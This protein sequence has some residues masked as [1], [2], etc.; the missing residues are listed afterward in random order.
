MAIGFHHGDLGVAEI[1]APASDFLDA[2]LGAAGPARLWRDLRVDPIAGPA[3][4][5]VISGVYDP[6]RDADEHLAIRDLPAAFDL[7]IH[8]REVTAVRWLP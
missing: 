5:R 4:L 3:K 2:T 1:P 6:V 7:L 8:L